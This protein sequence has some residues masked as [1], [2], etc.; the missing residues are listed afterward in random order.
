M[1]FHRRLNTIDQVTL[2][3]RRAP[4]YVEANNIRI[5]DGLSIR[6][7]ESMYLREERKVKKIKITKLGSD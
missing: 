4:C 3:K 7:K 2:L 5:N 1:I 6:T